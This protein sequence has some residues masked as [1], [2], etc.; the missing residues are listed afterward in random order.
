MNALL[1][2]KC[3][4]MGNCL[5]FEPT[6]GMLEKAR[7]AV[8]QDKEAQTQNTDMDHDNQEFDNN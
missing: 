1:T 7:N 6:V 3:N 8:H 5:D 2:L 4:Y